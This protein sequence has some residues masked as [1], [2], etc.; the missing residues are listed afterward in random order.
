MGF[1]VRL[2]SLAGQV[3]QMEDLEPEFT[4][5]FLRKRAAELLGLRACEVALTHGL[6]RLAKEHLPQ[7]LQEVGIRADAD[8][9]YV[10]L[11]R[12][13][14]PVFEGNW[15]NSRGAKILING[16][17]ARI[18]N[19]VTYQVVLNDEETVIGVEHMQIENMMG[20]DQISFRTGDVWHRVSDEGDSDLSV[21][22]RTVAG[23][24]FRVSGFNPSDT[25]GALRASAY[26]H[27][28]EE[29]NVQLDRLLFRIGSDPITAADDEL[30]LRHFGIVDGTSLL[31]LG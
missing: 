26:E 20:V 10:R 8:L 31:C 3:K 28:K 29:I 25:I 17:R 2:R 9:S 19:L 15:V 27:V 22:F 13:T 6:Q 12:L 7:T 24:S 21:I 30:S 18:A 14:L 23:A 5:A 4:V 16:D 1:S 11:P